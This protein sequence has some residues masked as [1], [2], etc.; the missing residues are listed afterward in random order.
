MILAALIAHLGSA[1]ALFI[2]LSAELRPALLR[3]PQPAHALALEPGLRWLLAA[4]ALMPRLTAL[5]MVVVARGRANGAARRWLGAGF[6]VLAAESVVRAI[7]ALAASRTMTV[8]MWVERLRP[9]AHVVSATA[10]LALAGCCWALARAEARA[11]ERGSADGPDV[12]DIQ[13]AGAI[14]WWTAAL[15]IGVAHVVA[16]LAV[17]FVLRLG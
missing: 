14:M 11:V 5:P 16:P 13:D 9:P 1:A 6:A 12:W 8:A 4:F 2:V 17:A 10:T 15:S 3:A 7:A